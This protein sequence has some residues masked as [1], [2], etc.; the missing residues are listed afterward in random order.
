MYAA[1]QQIE[2]L[3]VDVVAKESLRTIIS[4]LSVIQI[5]TI[6]EAKR[7]IEDQTFLRFLYFYVGMVVALLPT[8]IS[9]PMIM[10]NS[11]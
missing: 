6:N 8:C 1:L 9:F 10:E 4:L 3:T 2:N 11:K 7:K 5:M